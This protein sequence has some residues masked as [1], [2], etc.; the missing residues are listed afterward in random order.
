MYRVA[1]CDDD[2]TVCSQLEKVI[3][4]YAKRQSQ[5]L[6]VDVYTSGEEMCRCM[7]D[8]VEYHVIFLDIEL[9]MLNGVEIG[10]MIR[11]EMKD[12]IVHIIYISA[13]QGYAMELFAIRPL[14][15]LIKPLKEEEII[16]NLEKSIELSNKENKVYEFRLGKSYYKIPLKDVYYFA[17]EGKKVKI[18]TNYEELEYYGKLADVKMTLPEDDFLA[19]H[20][21][22]IVNC[23]YI[24]QYKYDSIT[25][26]NHEELPISQAFRKEIRDKLLNQRRD[27]K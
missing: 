26:T 24:I 8:S 9:K 14:N 22:Y 16:K 6:E 1:I 17:S 27:R 3:L 10:K 18:V 25:L 19:I 15:F 13:V 20:K 23:K 7:K 5:P 12:E 4:E 2:F 11:E 21:S